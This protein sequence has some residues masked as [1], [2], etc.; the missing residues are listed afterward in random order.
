MTD[1]LMEKVQFLGIG[2]VGFSKEIRGG[3]SPR[4]SG[5]VLKGIIRGGD[6]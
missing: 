6:E 5:E 2:E 3:W 4:D 1:E